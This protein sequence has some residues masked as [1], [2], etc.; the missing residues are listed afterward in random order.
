[1]AHQQ[2]IDG[3]I[4]K[5]YSEYLN[6]GGRTASKSEITEAFKNIQGEVLADYLGD[7]E[8]DAHFAEKLARKELDGA[9]AA[10]L[11]SPEGRSATPEMQ[12]KRFVEIRQQYAAVQFGVQK[13]ASEPK[14]L[15]LKGISPRT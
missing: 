12:E 9:L 13:L 6:D 3:Q 4:A 14:E 7:E 2:E 11:Q 5:K 1:M 8:R 10:Y 15:E